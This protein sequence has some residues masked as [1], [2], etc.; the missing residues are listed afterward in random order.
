ML[1]SSPLCD[2]GTRQ[3]WVLRGLARN[4]QELQL[5]PFQPQAL[6]EITWAGWPADPGTGWRWRT[7][8]RYR[9]R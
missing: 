4:Q 9:Y 7:T 1:T 6:G 2:E 5:R 8:G 3:R